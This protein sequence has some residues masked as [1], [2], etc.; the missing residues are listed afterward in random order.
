MRPFLLV[1][2]ASLAAVLMA[3]FA[4]AN[5]HDADDGPPLPPPPPDQSIQQPAA[6]SG[7]VPS[8]GTPS[9]SGSSSEAAGSPLGGLLVPVLI[10][11]GVLGLGFAAFMLLRKSKPGKA[12]PKAVPQSAAAQLHAEAQ[13]SPLY[14]VMSRYERDI[15]EKRLKEKHS[16]QRKILQEFGKTQ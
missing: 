10:G 14:M 13:K 8:S 1:L 11:V 7:S 9:S 3:S 6:G 4:A 5:Y 2:L 12:Q 15:Y 16:E